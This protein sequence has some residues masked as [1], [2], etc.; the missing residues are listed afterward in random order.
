VNAPAR[1]RQQVVQGLE[2]ATY[3]PHALHTDSQVWVEKNCYAD[4]WIEML[5]VLGLDPHAMLAFALAVDFE[6]DQW[7]FFKPPHADLYTLYGIDVQELTVWR[8]LVEHLQEHLAG[9]KWISTEADA[10]WLPDTAGTDYRRQHTKTTIVVNDLDLDRQRLGYFH[11]ASYYALEGEDFQHLLGI[12]VAA[13][14]LPLF[15]ELV[16]VDRVRRLHPAD[17]RRLAVSMLVHQFERR[18]TTNPVRRFADRFTR[19]LPH[20]HERGLQHYHQWAFATI[21]Q[22]GSAFE[23]AAAH[24]RWHSAD[25]AA[26]Q[27]AARA[28]MRIAE[29]CKALILKAARSV[30]HGRPMDAAPLLDAMAASWDEAMTRAGDFVRG[31]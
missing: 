9:G 18:P 11:N 19:E 28:C 12:D 17:L 14:P 30:A 6:G 27:D 15:A 2:P 5:H 13:G 1:P 16:R 26:P 31:R 21:R 29:G 10:W 20:L 3:R 25:H 4:V 23:L 7:T 22:C 24:L 8:P